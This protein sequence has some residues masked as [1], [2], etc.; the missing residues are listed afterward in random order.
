MQ[1]PKKLNPAI[2]TLIVIVLVGIVATIVI[3]NQPKDSTSAED[4]VQTETTQT[5]TK[6]AVTSTTPEET[7][8]ETSNTGTSEVASTYKDGTYTK[9]GSYVSPGGRESINVTLTVSNDV[10]TA[11][12]ITGNANNGESKEHQNDFIAGYKSLVVGKDIDSVSLSRVAGSS[13]TTNG[14]NSALKLIKADAKA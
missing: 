2:A 9:T 14:F 8:T 13:L 6:E 1:Q 7:T 4:S 5:E 11:A 3:V 10:I 12:T